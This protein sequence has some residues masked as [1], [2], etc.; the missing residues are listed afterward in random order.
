MTGNDGLDRK[1]LME[2]DTALLELLD[3]RAAVTGPVEKRVDNAEYYSRLL[4]EYEGAYDTAFIQ[5]L[6]EGLTDASSKQ[7]DAEEP[8]PL[9]VS[10]AHQSADT[11]VRI[12][13]AEIGGDEPA[14]IFGPCSVESYSQVAE[15]A[16][17]LKRKGLKMIRGGAFK[18]RTSPY[19]FQGLGKEGLEILLE[20]K[21]AHDLAVVS[22]IVAPEHVNLAE[23]HL[24]A[25]QIGARNMQNFELLKAVGRSSKPVILKRGMSATIEEFLY[26]AE[27]IL[28][29]GN[30]N[31]V[32]CER[33]IRTYEKSTRNTLDISA[34]PLLKQA[35][36]LP[37]L[38]DVTHSTGR[39]EIMA[40]CAKA[41]L[42]AG[43]DGIMA[44][45][46]PDPP[47]ALSD[48]AQQMTLEEFDKF[49]LSII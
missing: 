21:K 1:K 35:S 13:E 31:V 16:S 23:A 3:S 49:H 38:V 5:A 14:H 11:I 6:L 9:L 48:K 45:V 46:H 30:G 2:I 28:A 43:A 12:G 37:V 26:A 10:R 17:D 29:E 15:V 36:H 39:K 24:D 34:V 33:G 19:D 22:E 25:F 44:E 27:Y 42:A 18:P 32:F 4:D 47:T 41:A 20:I 40:D 8:P 7:A